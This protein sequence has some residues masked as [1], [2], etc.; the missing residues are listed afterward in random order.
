MKI[1]IKKQRNSFT[2]I[3]KNVFARKKELIPFHDDAIDFI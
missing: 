1:I 2:I 3:E